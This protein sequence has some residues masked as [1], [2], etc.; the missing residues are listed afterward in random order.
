MLPTVDCSTVVEL[1]ALLG[2]IGDAVVSV[3]GEGALDITGAVEVTDAAFEEEI[4]MLPE[5]AGFETAVKVATTWSGN[6]MIRK[7]EFYVG[8]GAER[9]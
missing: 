1:A 2:A 6:A 5:V 4:D 9:V 3:V 7:Y 8:R